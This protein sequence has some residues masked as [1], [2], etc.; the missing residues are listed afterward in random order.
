MADP[1]EFLSSKRE[2]ELAEFAEWLADRYFDGRVVDPESLA[3][4]KRITICRNDY[5]TAF[6]GLLEQ[7]AGR[8]CIYCNTARARVP[9]RV[10]FTVGH[11]LGH[12]FIDEHREAL[13]SGSV[14]EHGSFCDFRSKNPVEREADFFAS[15]LLMPPSRLERELARLPVSIET[16]LRVARRF[17]T[18]LTSAAVRIVEL[19]RGICALVLWQRGAFP[20]EAALEGRQSR[21]ATQ[22]TSSC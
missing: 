14:K 21:R 13:L 18:S 4:E 6:D 19:N 2:E 15:N 7:R 8:F 10:R 17:Q 20:L 12:F 5:G 9:E 3:R 1:T 16:V 11:E 22:R